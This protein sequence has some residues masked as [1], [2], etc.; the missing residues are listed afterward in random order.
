M[1]ELVKNLKKLCDVH[2]QHLINIR[3]RI[4]DIEGIPKAKALVGKCFKY[5]GGSGMFHYKKNWT[6][7][8]VVASA[9][10]YVFV[11]T[12]EVNL[13]S[14]NFEVTFAVSESAVNFGYQSFTEITQKQYVAAYKNVI[15]CLTKFGQKRGYNGK[16]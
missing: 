12:I 16:K 3:T 4:R 8:R 14:S 7:K 5:Q 9:G 15:K 6:Y 1:S 2:E 13:K 11:D 10:E